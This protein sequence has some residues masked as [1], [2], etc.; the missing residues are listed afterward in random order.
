VLNHDNAYLHKPLS[1][2]PLA[3]CWYHG[4]TVGPTN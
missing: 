2:N 1:A 4:A 3:A